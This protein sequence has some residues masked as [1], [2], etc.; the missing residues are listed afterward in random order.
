M[1]DTTPQCNPECAPN[2]RCV[3]SGSVSGSVVGVG[4]N[5]TCECAPGHVGEP[6][7]RLAGCIYLKPYEVFVLHGTLLW[8]L[9]LL[10][11]DNSSYFYEY[12]I[13]RKSFI[14]IQ[15]INSN[16]A[17]ISPY[18]A[19]STKLKSFRFDTS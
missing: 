16:L 8:T 13:E 9:D 2:A 7:G 15:F 19:N 5:N 11:G 10:N 6:S 12:S 18:I 3:A 17:Q 1:N 14:V 4:V